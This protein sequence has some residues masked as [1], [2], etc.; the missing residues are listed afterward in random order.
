MRT[1]RQAQDMQ[2][3]FQRPFLL[4]PLNDFHMKARSSQPEACPPVR[5]A[6][7]KNRNNVRT[8]QHIQAL[9]KFPRDQAAQDFLDLR[10]AGIWTHRTRRP[11]PSSWFFWIGY[12][13]LREPESPPGITRLHPTQAARS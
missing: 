9:R 13:L 7:R 8:V 11:H 2:R 12:P 4:R 5:G 6:A 3:I 1:T 10:A